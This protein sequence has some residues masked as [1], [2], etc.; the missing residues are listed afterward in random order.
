MCIRLSHDKESAEFVVL[1]AQIA[2]DDA[3]WNS[4][5][6]HQGGEAGGVVLAK[7]DAATEKEFVEIVPFVF[8]R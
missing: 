1:A 2:D 3:R 6:S 5:Q 4:S 7:T 8:A